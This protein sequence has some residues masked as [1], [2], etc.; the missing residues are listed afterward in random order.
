MAKVVVKAL[1]SK[2]LSSSKAS[3]VKMKRF[4]DEAGRIKNVW[5]VDARSGSFGGDLLNV[6]TKNVRKARQEN[7]TALG[8]TDRVP[9]KK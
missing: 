9:K 5:S 3:S 4:V 7:K 2:K 6:F 1:K 8:S